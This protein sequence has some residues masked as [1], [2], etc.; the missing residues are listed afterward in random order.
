[1]PFRWNL[2]EHLTLAADLAKRLCL[3][4]PTAITT[5]SAC[6]LFLWSL[7]CV[8]Q[9]HWQFPWLLYLLPLAGVGI[10]WLYH[11]H[12]REVDAGSSLII[13]QIH[14]PGGGVPLRM[15]PLILLT[16]LITH[17][18]GGSAGREGTAVQMG[19]SIAS[20]FV[21]LS[22]GLAPADIRLLLMAG[23]AAGFGGVFGTPLAGAIFA[24][25]VLTIG[26]L[27]HDALIPCLLAAIISD[28]T[29]CAW[30]IEH[31][32]YSVAALPSHDWIA[33]LDWLLLGKVAVASIAFGLAAVLFIELTHAIK[34]LSQRVITKP[35]LRPFFGGLI[36]IALTILVGSRDYL[37]L[38]VD[39]SSPDSVTI[40]SCFSA[41]GAHVGS[42][43]WKLLFTA[44]TLGT[45]FKGGEV[46][47][48]FFIGAALGHT[49]AG[50]LGAPTDLFAAI[51]F[52]AIFAGATKTPLACTLMAIELFGA[53]HA[54]YYAVGCCLAYV[55]SG[56]SSIYAAASQKQPQVA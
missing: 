27:S 39:A 11:R 55:V 21:K 44:V 16:T 56:Q 42:W 51:G 35:V 1:M 54:T 25:E 10:S 24:L 41:D 6:A 32:H 9:W 48:L 23:I 29:C 20:G 26:R 15:A 18:F 38:G 49:L 33:H 3:V 52:V 19:G 53:E 14:H 30:G 47:P 31:T 40:V 4:A 7:K 46:T 50:A 5:G 17:L 28:W 45:G 22:R 2:R 13:E 8:T 34:S 43:W 37:G 12:G 36:V